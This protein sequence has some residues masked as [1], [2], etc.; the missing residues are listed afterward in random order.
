VIEL[1]RAIAVAMERGPAAGLELIEAIEGLDRYAPFH[2]SRADL[3]GRLDR[4]AEAVEAYRRGLEL[5]T[6]PV[7]RT[8]LEGRIAELEKNVE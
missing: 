5:S 8:F 7:Q 6:N 1:N 3:L 2:V 4:D